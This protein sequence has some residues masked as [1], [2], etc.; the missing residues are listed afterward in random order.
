MVHMKQRSILVAAFILTSYLAVAQNAGRWDALIHDPS[1]NR[2]LG[3]DEEDVAGREAYWS[4]RRNYPLDAAPAGAYRAAYEQSRALPVV[5]PL[6][7]KAIA[8]AN[9]WTF[10][11][12]DNIGGR[13]NSIAVNPRN[14]RSI[15]IAAADGGVWKTENSGMSWRS[16]FDDAPTQAMGCVAIDP[17]DTMVMYAGTGEGNYSGDSYF[18]MGLLKSTDAGITWFSCADTSFPANGTVQRIV[19][20]PLNSSIVYAS[21]PYV[22]GYTQG[23]LFR[24]RDGG[25]TWTLVL[26]GI[27]HEFAVDPTSGGHLIVPATSAISSLKSDSVGIFITTDGGDSWQRGSMPDAVSSVMGRVAI[28]LCATSPNIVYAGIAENGGSRPRLH[29]VFKSTNGGLDW[30]KLPIPIDYVVPQGSYDNILMVNPLVPNWVVV[31]GVRLLQSWDGGY[32][33]SY[34]PVSFYNDGVVHSDQHAC[35]FDPRN[36]DTMLIGNDGGFYFGTH[37]GS[38]WEKRCSGY[39]VTQFVGGSMYPGNPSFT[40]GGT[41]D[42][43]TMSASASPSM[44]QILGGDGG[45]TAIHP[46]HPNVLFS[47]QFG[48]SLH[49]STDL[50]ATW[51][52]C[53]NGIPATEQSLFYAPFTLD[54]LNGDVM[55]YGS[56]NMWKSTDGGENWKAMASCLFSAG[57]FSCYYCATIRVSPYNDSFVYAGSTGG[58]VMFSTDMGK[59]WKGRSAGLPGRVVSSLCPAPGKAV[60]ASLQG[61]GSGHVFRFDPDSLKWYDISGDLPDAPANTIVVTSDGDICVGTLVGVYILAPGGGSPHWS[62][63]GAGLPAVSVEHLLYDPPSGVLRAVTHGRGFWD[64]VMH[65]PAATRPRFTSLPDTAGVFDGQEYVYAPIILSSPTATVTGTS[66]RGNF[67]L[68]P[69][70]GVVRWSGVGGTTITLTARNSAGE[71]SQTFSLPGKGLPGATD[72]VV[73]GDAGVGQRPYAMSASASALWVAFDSGYVA[74]SSD[75]GATWRTTRF[76]QPNGTVGTIVALNDQVACAGTWGGTIWRTSDAGTT[77]NNMRHDDNARYDNIAFADSVHGWAVSNGERDTMMQVITTDAGVSWTK[78]PTHFP[79]MRPTLNSMFFFDTLRGWVT[80]NNRETS[81][82]GNAQIVRTT[83]G[84]ISWLSSSSAQTWVSGVSFFDGRLGYSVDA[85]GGTVFR[86][87]DGGA[88]WSKVTAP[89][90][91]ANL[92][93]VWTSPNGKMGW[94]VGDQQAWVTGDKGAHWSATTL[95][96][97]GPL[98][99][100][101]FRDSSHGWV[102]GVNGIVEEHTSNPPVSVFEQVMKPSSEGFAYPNP[103]SSSTVVQFMRTGGEMPRVELYDQLGRVVMPLIAEDTEGRMW[104]SAR[105]DVSRL[106][107]GIYVVVARTNTST[108]RERLVVVR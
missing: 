17:R 73:V 32:T 43:G 13:T 18:G 101:A 2:V 78:V 35:A 76:A 29:G 70:T 89:T 65:A 37:A 74:R 11:G 81:P 33:W 15:F 71:A 54:P 20:D 61:Y 38:H 30:V 99:A 100:A 56:V 77:W 24:S 52:R 82:P 83:N 106:E 69:S 47:E 25:A 6:R 108:Q 59:T 67:V 97:I 5:H 23:G 60:Y 92:T 79:S 26:K 12:P 27:V 16:V 14:S 84:G 10:V 87:T 48:V 41:Q 22:T 72:W 96:P 9:D 80:L 34:I 93:D 7:G 57:S 75:N 8:G 107:P 4:Q 45:F 66:T 64:L 51:R 103:A 105:V 104:I 42:N 36:P 98:A 1:V 19:V 53:T 86:S 46:Q 68:N 91:V 28:D 39:G 95:V 21:V 3:S 88:T 62:R 85:F 55:Y 44:D 58:T 94:I 49:K 90:A 31:G 102:I 63:L 40:F 50:G